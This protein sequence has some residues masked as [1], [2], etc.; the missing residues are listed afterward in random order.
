M[1][2][3]VLN[4]EQLLYS[5]VILDSNPTEIT[6]ASS[7]SNEKNTPRLSVLYALFFVGP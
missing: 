1:D 7:R 3:H 2:A 4:R 5:A 6:E